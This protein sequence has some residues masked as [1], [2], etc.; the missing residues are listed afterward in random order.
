MANVEFLSPF[1]PKITLWVLSFGKSGFRFQISDFSI[2]SE[3]RNPSKS[4]FGFRAVLLGNPKYGFYNRNPDFEST[5]MTSLRLAQKQSSGTY[6]KKK[7]P[8]P[9][10]FLGY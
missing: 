1:W 10:Q 6:Q 3:I 7:D 5:P 2:K 4:V 8:V 9:D